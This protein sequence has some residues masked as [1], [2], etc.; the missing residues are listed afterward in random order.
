MHRRRRGR[1]VLL[2]EVPDIDLLV[3]ESRLEGKPGLTSV[4]L[5]PTTWL[6]ICYRS[7]DRKAGLSSKSKGRACEIFEALAEPASREGLQSDV[8]ATPKARAGTSPCSERVGAHRRRHMRQKRAED[9]PKSERKLMKLMMLVL[10][11]CAPPVGFL[12]TVGSIAALTHCRR[13]ASAGTAETCRRAIEDQD[14][15]D[16]R[17]CAVDDD[18][19][20]STPGPTA[21]SRDS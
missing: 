3:R 19:L 8:A 16:E 4:D 1:D 17:H 14:E 18:R 11:R 21:P 12:M 5:L 9:R 15:T 10:F 2:N 20:A 13:Q 7:S 6:A